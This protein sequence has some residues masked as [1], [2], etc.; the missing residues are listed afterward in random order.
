[1][2]QYLIVDNQDNTLTVVKISDGKQVSSYKIQTSLEDLD[3]LLE[4]LAL[5]IPNKAYGE[6]INT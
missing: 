5:T 6:E 1:M 3:L 4:R 2:I